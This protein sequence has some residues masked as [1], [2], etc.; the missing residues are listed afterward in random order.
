MTPAPRILLVQDRPSS[1]DYQQRLFIDEAKRRGLTIDVTKFDLR[2]SPTQI[3]DQLDR[4]ETWFDWMVTDLLIDGVDHDPLKSA[5]LG[6][7]KQLV[8]R[9]LFGSHGPRV[10]KPRGV[11]CIAVCSVC[12]DYGAVPLPEL[13]TA[14]AD[15]KLRSEF[16]SRGGDV[17]EL[18]KRVLDELTA[19]AAQ[20]R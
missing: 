16:F 7:L 17:S 2:R 6:L 13:R 4:Q 14:L 19:A 1:L 20:G 5:G 12:V 10:P 15:L 8:A 9:N 11:R 18:A 3:L